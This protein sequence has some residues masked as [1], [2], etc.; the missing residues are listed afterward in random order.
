V[1]IEKLKKQSKAFHK[2]ALLYGTIPGKEFYSNV[3]SREA[4]RIDDEIDAEP[5]TLRDRQGRPVS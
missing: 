2:F 4:E 1:D 3:L 5:V